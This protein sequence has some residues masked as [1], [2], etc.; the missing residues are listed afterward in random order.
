MGRRSDVF[1]AS[2]LILFLELA[3]IRWFPAHVLFLTYFTNTVLFAAFLGMSPGC[4]AAG[5]R[6]DGLAWSGVLLAFSMAAAQAIARWWTVPRGLAVAVEEKV[7]DVVFFG[8]E[9]PQA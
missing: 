5:R 4:L 7:P 1:L 8:A 2:L 9:A 3:C 6:W